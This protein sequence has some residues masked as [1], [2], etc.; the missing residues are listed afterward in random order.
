MD[1]DEYLAEF[2]RLVIEMKRN[3]EEYDHF[4][5]WLGQPTKVLTPDKLIEWN[6]IDQETD[7]LRVAIRDL[8]LH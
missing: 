2:K 4:I 8:E 5:G 1:R 7:R 6:R 3:A